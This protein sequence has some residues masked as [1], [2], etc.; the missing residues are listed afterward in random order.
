MEQVSNQQQ[1]TTVAEV[2]QHYKEN[3][4]KAGE[5]GA[6]YDR[7]SASAYDDFCK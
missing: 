1:F 2:V 7:M 3:Y 6:F 5:A 4:P